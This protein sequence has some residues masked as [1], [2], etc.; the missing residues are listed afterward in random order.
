MTIT[1][2]APLGARKTA[3]G[4]GDGNAGNGARGHSPKQ[5]LKPKTLALIA[6]LGV[7]AAQFDA[8]GGDCLTRADQLGRKIGRNSWRSRYRRAVAL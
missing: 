6:S 7:I 5:A 8:T 2:P 3:N 4:F 1:V